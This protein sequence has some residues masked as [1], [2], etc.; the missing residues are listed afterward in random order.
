MDVIVL[1]WII[2]D[3]FRYSQVKPEIFNPDFSSQIEIYFHPTNLKS[4]I[5]NLWYKPLFNILLQQRLPIV[6]A[7]Q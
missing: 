7:R 2:Q 5:N 3:L 6:V 1:H 4:A